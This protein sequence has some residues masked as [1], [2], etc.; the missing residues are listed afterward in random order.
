MVIVNNLIGLVRSCNVVFG[1]T[2]VRP[3]VA[4]KEAMFNIFID[5]DSVWRGEFG[6]ENVFS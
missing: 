6:G 4:V 2:K 5:S 3:K 1:D